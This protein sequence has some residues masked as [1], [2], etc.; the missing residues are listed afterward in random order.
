MGHKEPFA[1]LARHG[2]GRRRRVTLREDQDRA[3]RVARYIAKVSECRAH[4][5]TTTHPGD[6][7]QWLTLV[8]HWLRMAQA[9]DEG[10]W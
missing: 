8:A 2:D 9:A 1:R 4:A 10:R 3:S 5:E 7:E 6:K